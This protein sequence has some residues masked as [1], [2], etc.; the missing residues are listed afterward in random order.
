[1]KKEVIVLFLIIFTSLVSAT[2]QDLPESEIAT[3]TFE[4]LVNEPLTVNGKTITLEDDGINEAYVLVDGDRGTIYFNNFQYINGV[5][6]HLLNIKEK[7]VH[8]NL[9]AFVNITTYGVCG[10]GI[11]YDR[12]SCCTDC[13]CDIGETCIDNQCILNT[14]QEYLESLLPSEKVIIPECAINEDCATGEKC[15]GITQ[16]CYKVG[17]QEEIQLKEIKEEII[18]QEP[19]KEKSDNTSPIIVIIL[20]ILI[21][22]FI[23]YGWDLFLR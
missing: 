12:E 8:G 4:L 9:S 18:I 1:M 16:T 5:S 14:S 11:C 15:S 3:E 21:I 6:I 23:L 17:V 7:N 10:D 20:E 19:I 2:V 22:L 13:G